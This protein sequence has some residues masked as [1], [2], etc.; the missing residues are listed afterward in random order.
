MRFSLSTSGLARRSGMRP[1]RVFAIWLVIL[2]AAGVAATG[3]AD[4]FT[5]EANLTNNPESVQAD[6]LLEG[7]L[8]G[9]RPA[10]ETVVVHSETLTSDDPAFQQ[11]VADATAAL[12]VASDVVAQV[13][14][15]FAAV[16]SGTV[17][18]RAV[19]SEDRHTVIIPVTLVGDID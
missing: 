3:L 15:P 1:R 11:V 7:R 10:T 14:D 4:A 19:I 17:P 5:T 8:R 2:I 18:E 9:P 16:A 12:A 6:D 13:T